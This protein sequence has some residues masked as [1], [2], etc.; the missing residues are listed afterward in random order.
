MIAIAREDFSFGCGV[1]NNVFFVFAFVLE[2]GLAAAGVELVLQ[3]M[4]V[5]VGLRQTS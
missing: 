2:R 5:I 3:V 1:G 4:C